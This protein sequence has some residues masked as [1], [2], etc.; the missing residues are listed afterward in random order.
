MAPKGVSLI[1]EAKCKNENPETYL[2]E[3]VR[4]HNF[5]VLLSSKV[6]QM[7]FGSTRGI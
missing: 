2:D 6:G 4:K 7:A 5:I 1:K 3:I